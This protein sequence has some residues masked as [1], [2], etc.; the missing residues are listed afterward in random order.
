[1]LE[2]VIFKFFLL[3]CLSHVF[4][5]HATWVD[6]IAFDKGHCETNTGGNSR[7]TVI[8]SKLASGYSGTPPKPPLQG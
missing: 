7:Y 5:N 1:M 3:R 8:L 2:L 6:C 4:R